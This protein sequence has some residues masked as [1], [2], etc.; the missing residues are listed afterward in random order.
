MSAPS[1]LFEKVGK[2]SV[3]KQRRLK[4]EF[5]LFKLNLFS[6]LSLKLR[7]EFDDIFLKIS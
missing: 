2:L 7:S 4:S 5:S 6:D 1:K 3:G